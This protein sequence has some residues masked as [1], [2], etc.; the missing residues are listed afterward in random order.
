MGIGNRRA[1]VGYLEEVHEFAR[2]FGTTYSVVM[3]DID[4][5]KS[6]NDT[7]GHIQG[8]EVLRKIADALR[9][10][11]RQVDKVFR[12]GGEEMLAV[13]PQASIEGAA[14]AA[15]RYRAS[16]EN[17]AIPHQGSGGDVVTISLGV[18]N[19]FGQGDLPDDWAHVVS[20]ADRALYR[21]KRSG[22]NCVST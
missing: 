17:L 3:M 7:Y 20:Q 1:M 9:G 2:R 6:Y 11:L 10:T 19:C 12:Y 8:D 21:S 16:V 22:K 5:F 13:L 14:G 18:A 4:D 15:E